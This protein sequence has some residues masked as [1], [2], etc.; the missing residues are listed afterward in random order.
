MLI[1]SVKTL[2]DGTMSSISGIKNCNEIEI[3][4]NNF[5]EFCREIDQ[6]VSWQEA[7]KMFQEKPSTLE[8]AFIRKG[9]SLGVVDTV[10]ELDESIPMANQ[11]TSTVLELDRHGNVTV[12]QLYVGNGCGPDVYNGN[13]RIWFIQGHPS[14]DRMASWLMEALPLL[15]RVHDSNRYGTMTEDAME[16]S[17]E[18]K[19]SLDHGC[20]N[21]DN[22]YAWTDASE[23]FKLSPPSVRT[24][25][26]C[27]KE[28]D[29]NIVLYGVEQY[30]ESLNE[31][32]VDQAFV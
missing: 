11:P 20:A 12:Q 6:D 14:D 5:I 1:E 16:A 17:H 23:W 2:S 28:T 22:D 13:T 19:K 24:I 27:H 3:L 9:L 30:L 21:D 29:S 26:G 18:I 7:W 32:M 10:P 4:R 15:A 25:E 8:E 31:K